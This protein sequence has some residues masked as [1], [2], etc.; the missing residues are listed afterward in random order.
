MS[1][2]WRKGKRI[3]IA[4]AGP[5]G[6]SAALELIS[7][8]FDV[9]IY[10]KAAEPK[11]LGGAVLLSTPVLAIMRKYGVDVLSLGSKTVT[12]F[13]NNK[14]KIRAT[15]PFNKDVEKSF[16]I[17]GWHYG[18]LRS[19]AFGQ[20]LEHLPKDVIIGGKECIGYDEVGDEVIVRFADGTSE[21]ADMLIGADGINSAVSRQAFG[22]PEIFHIGLRVIL[23]W[24]EDFGG[25]DRSVG[26]I[27]HS[28]NV[29]ASYFPMLHDGKPGWEWWIVEKSD[30]T[31]TITDLEAHM[32]RHVANFAD[33]MPQFAAHTDFN[34]QAFVWEIRNRP[35]LQKWSK[36][37]I[38]CVG[39]AVHPVSPYAAYGMGMAIEDGYFLARALGG[40]DLTDVTQIET[41]CEKYEGERIAYV[42]HH[43]EFARELGDR[44]HKAPGFVARLRDFVFD[45]TGVLEKLIRK[46]YLRDAELMSLQLSELHQK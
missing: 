32:K 8:G 33:P 46:D 26:V 30:G 44:F 9:R 3:A 28:R 11:P 17:P 12:K 39:D 20:M 5:G 43:V 40:K 14:G 13:A 10:E 16:G 15:L 41:A 34:S 23:A 31:E 45:N 35:S 1:T 18:M 7:Q 6:V 29:Q 25:I 36:G 37:R 38:A 42:N 2:N 19:N 21:T 4:G 27:H 24:C 22:D